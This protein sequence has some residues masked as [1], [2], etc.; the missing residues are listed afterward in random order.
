M[1]TWLSLK[2]ISTNI[3]NLPF[4]R[5]TARIPFQPRT[6]RAPPTSRAERERETRGRTRPLSSLLLLPPAHR[7]QT[8]PP[9]NPMAAKHLLSRAR[10]LIARHRGRPTILPPVLSRF[11]FGGTTQR[12][13]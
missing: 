12:P 3:F 7:P 9:P 2:F 4:P 11:L 10:L 13:E 8:P 5:W 6:T 1:D